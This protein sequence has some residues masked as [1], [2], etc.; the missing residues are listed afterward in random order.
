MDSKNTLSNVENPGGDT[1]PP[2]AEAM[3]GTIPEAKSSQTGVSVRYV[4][5]PDYHWFVFRVSYGR[6]AKALDFFV[7]HNTFA[8][9]AMRYVRE[10]V[11]GKPQL[12]LKALIPNLIFVYTT[13]Q[14][15]EKY[16]K[17]TPELSF[18]SFYYDHFHTDSNNHNP[19]LIIPRREMENFILATQNHNEHLM[20]VNHSQCHYKGGER[21]CVIDGP[22]KGVEGKVARVAGQQRV[23]LSIADIGLIATAYIPS[24]FIQ[25]LPA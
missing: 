5:H 8:Y 15:A 25:I 23:I 4:L 24:A 21:V 22:F 7:E 14:Q 16:V 3:I 13:T 17:K 10:A 1:I 9:V 2:C 20:V 18:V 19:P 6:G 12:V 11:N